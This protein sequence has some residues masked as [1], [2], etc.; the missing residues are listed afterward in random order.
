MP[1]LHQSRVSRC[2]PLR[3]ELVAVWQHLRRLGPG[4]PHVYGSMT[5]MLAQQYANTPSSTT[6]VLRRCPG[7]GRAIH[8][9]HRLVSRRSPRIPPQ[10]GGHLTTTPAIAPRSIPGLTPEQLLSLAPIFASTTFAT[11]VRLSSCLGVAASRCISPTAMNL[12]GACLRPTTS[13]TL[14]LQSSK[15]AV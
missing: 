12:R 11:T 10:R 13:V 5:G 7:I 14:V 4:N 1:L 6:N 8:D 9:W 15:P 2:E 3:N